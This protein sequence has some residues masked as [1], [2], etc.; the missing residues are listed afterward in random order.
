MKRS[1]ILTFAAAFF[2]LTACQKEVSGPVQMKTVRFQAT[3][4]ETKAIFGTPSGNTYPTLWTAKPEQ[5]GISLNLDTQV[6]ADV[7]PSADFKTATFSATFEAAETGPYTFVAFHPI[8]AVRSINKSNKTLNVEF[9]SSQTSQATTPDENAEIVYAISQE[10]TTFPE[11]VVPLSFKHVPAY[12]HLTFSNATLGDAKVSAVNITASTKITGRWFYNRADGSISE[13]ATGNTISVA[14]DQLENV[15]CALAPVDL[16]NKTLTFVIATDKGTIT[17]EITL[18]A[19]RKLASGK[20]AKLAVDLTGT[21]LVEPKIYKL[22]TNEDA[23]NIGDKVIIVSA[24]DLELALGT[25]Q[26]A[27]NRSAAAIVKEDDIISDPSASVQELTL[28]DGI[29]PGM[30]AFNTGA[31]YLYAAGGGNYLR[32]HA[33]KDAAATWDITIGASGATT[34]ISQA[35]GI[36]QTHIRYNNN[37]NSDGTVNNLFSAYG[38]SSSCKPVVLYRLDV[39]VDDTPRFEAVFNGSTK[40]DAEAQTIPVYVFGNVAWT[41]SITGGATLDKTSGTGPAILTASIPALDGADS[42]E[43]TITISTSASVTPASY[44]FTLTQAA[45]ATKTVE[46]NVKEYATAHN[47]VNSNETITSYNIEQDGVTL[48]ASWA[49]G[50]DPCGLWYGGDDWRFY[51]ARSGKVTVSVGADNQL[52]KAKFTYSTTKNGILLAPDGSQLAS[53]TEYTLSGQSATFSVGNTSTGTAGQVRIT[54]I[55]IV[56]K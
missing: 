37:T 20:I 35:S 8:S 9:P 43:Y 34:I 11:D 45:L 54:D 14:T 56:Y 36:T 15:W 30:Y 46:I 25:T 38:A 2:A 4:I 28:E 49:S 29:I 12:L 27:N 51:Q 53:G 41:A 40:I 22:V 23:L 18:P 6:P 33:A 44:T 21:A 3:D 50:K 24:G 10:Y 48:T 16:S 1:L 17:K 32:T 42:K 26:N 47:W 19:N 7:T 5:A 55:V 13:N 31:G 39:P 52:V